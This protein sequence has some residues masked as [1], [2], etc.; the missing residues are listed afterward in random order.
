MAKPSWVTVMTP[1]GTGNGSSVIATNT[2]TGR[3]ARS[4]EITGLT[5]GGASDKVSVTQSSKVEF[6]SLTTPSSTTSPVSINKAGQSYTIEGKSNSATLKIY[7]VGGS[8]SDKNPVLS[9]EGKAVSTT[10]W[11]GTDKVDVPNDPGKDAEYTFAITLTFPNNKTASKVTTN[12]Y[13]GNSNAS[14]KTANIVFEQ[15]AGTKSYDEPVIKTFS[16]NRTTL[17]AA[18]TDS[19]EP[20]ITYSQTWGWNDSTTDGGT[21]TT[22]GTVLYANS[23]AGSHMDSAGKVTAPSKGKI[24]SGETTLATVTATVTLNGKTSKKSNAITITQVANSYTVGKIEWNPNRLPSVAVIPAS[25]GERK[26]SDISWSGTSTDIKCTQT[27]TFTSTDTITITDRDGYEV[28]GGDTYEPIALSS[29]TVTAA[30]RGTTVGPEKTVGTLTIT[31]TGATSAIGVVSTKSRTLEV[32]QAANTAT[33]GTVTIGHASP[34]SIKPQG[35]TYKMSENVKADQT[36]S[37]T[38]GATRKVTSFGTT[39]KVKT[40]VTGFTLNDNTGDVTVT[41]NPTTSARN[42]FVVTLA[43]TGEGSKTASKDITFNQQGSATFITLS[44]KTITFAATGG[45]ETLTVT[46]NDSWTLS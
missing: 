3:V 9:I 8:I 38:S 31:A 7:P 13:I 39:Y 4:G 45:S 26:Y 33:Y 1:S 29:N 21:I 19:A 10:V 17:N 32:K 44:P 22:G 12:F 43:V 36:V 14:P 23:V 30:T 40:A 20:T 5:T 6:I 34:I 27:L 41:L 16:Y 37:Y 25:G 18:G 46:S 28:T 35:E 15:A 11:N 2:Y 42:G 24:I